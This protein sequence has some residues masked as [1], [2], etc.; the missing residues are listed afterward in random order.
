MNVV[1]ALSAYPAGTIS[2][3]FG[4]TG[5]L[6]RGIGFLVVADLILAFGSTIASVMLGVVFWGLH[7]GFT[8]GLLE[9][10]SQSWHLP[11]FSF[12]SAMSER[13]EPRR[14]PWRLISE[15]TIPIETCRGELAPEQSRSDEGGR[16]EDRF[17]FVT[18][19]LEAP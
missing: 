15:T 5:V 14:T 19:V 13:E 11:A 17:A 16:D 7:M 12:C 4:R 3:R 18:S 10:S 1:Y 9:Q 6:A 2:D 8:Q